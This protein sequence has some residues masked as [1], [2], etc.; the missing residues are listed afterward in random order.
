MCIRDRVVALTTGQFQNLTSAIIAALSSS[1]VAAIETAD[2]AALKT[3]QVTALGTDSIAALTTDQIGAITTAGIAAL[4]TS[5][6]AGLTTDQV[7]ALTTAQVQSLS[8]STIFTLSTDQVAAIESG[9][10]AVIKTSQIA[11]LKS[12]QVAALTTD[13]IVALTTGQFQNLTSATIAAL[14]TNQVAAIETADIAVLSTNQV[15]ALSTDNIAA[16][17]TDQ[18]GAIASAGIAALKTSQITAFTTDQ[19][20][21]LTTAQV[22]SLSTASIAALSTA[23]VAAFETADIQALRTTQIVALGTSG[24]AALTTDQF[25]ALTTAQKCAFTTNQVGAI[26]TENINALFPLS[27]P[28][29]LDLNGDG[30]KTLAISSGVK[31][32]LYANGN[33]VQTGWVSGGDGLL[34]LDRNHD[35]VIND[36]SELFGSSTTLANGQKATDGY[37][38]LSE[39]DSSHDGVISQVD[40]GFDDLR[41]W[42]DANSDGVSGAGEI[43]SLASLQ[44][45]QISLQASA[46]SAVD[47][48]NIL[49]LTSTYQTTDGATHAA[50]DVWFATGRPNDSQGLSTSDNIPLDK[51]IAALALSPP[52]SPPVPVSVDAAL[53]AGVDATGTLP[54][55]VHNEVQT[56]SDMRSRVSS[57]AQV[58]G[59]F[60]DAEQDGASLTA[61][62]PDVAGGTSVVGSAVTVAVANMAEVMK[63]FDAN[64]NLAGSANAAGVTTKLLNLTA[65]QDSANNG[66]LAV[67]GK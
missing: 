36:G 23:Q 31:F 50:A 2:I 64:G 7:V 10:I 43:Q 54:T 9:D 26:G 24:A 25:S 63:N 30:V 38:A 40:A 44:I 34:V 33:Q 4:K 61:P 27:T 1:Q 60:G 67:G 22:K 17:T 14:S 65:L 16:L 52:V 42:V 49:G 32:D 35:G 37:V 41:V 59:S 5:Q 57:M 19:V 62:R 11:V 6:I 18:I 29:V 3:N 51:A 56:S 21:A 58:M 15:T 47:N 13:Q 39:M 20:V 48:G 53:A 45:S 66:Y 12:S 46:G 55:Q 8:T 28:I